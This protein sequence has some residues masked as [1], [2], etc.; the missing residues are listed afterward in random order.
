METASLTPTL[1]IGVPL[2]RVVVGISTSRGSLRSEVERNEGKGGGKRKRVREICL[3]LF[4][5]KWASSLDEFIPLLIPAWRC[6]GG[7]G[8][9]FL[10][11]LVTPGEFLKRFAVAYRRYA[12]RVDGLRERLL[13]IRRSYRFNLLLP[14][15]PAQLRAE[16]LLVRE[17]GLVEGSVRGANILLG[18][19]EWERIDE[20]E[21]LSMRGMEILVD[22]LT[23]EGY[24]RFGERSDLL[25]SLI[26]SDPRLAR[27]LSSLWDPPSSGP[28]GHSSVSLL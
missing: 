12:D 18:I 28:R 16:D 2:A 20:L 5:S 13:Q 4:F 15:S 11:S 1:R 14:P 26:G 3:D 24:L 17:V 19:G 21:L 23:P 8:A 7:E 10:E 6:A 27:F 25:S 9:M 22:E